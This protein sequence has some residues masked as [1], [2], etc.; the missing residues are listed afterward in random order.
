M[1]VFTDERTAATWT[2]ASTSQE[3]RQINHFTPQAERHSVFS[4][5][6]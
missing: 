6:V 2:A 1:V 3:D 4:N 5:F